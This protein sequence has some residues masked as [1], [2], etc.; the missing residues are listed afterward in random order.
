MQCNYIFIHRYFP[1]DFFFLMSDLLPEA[2]GEK[3]EA[4][5]W[6]LRLTASRR[7]RLAG[8]HD[9]FLFCFLKDIFVFQLHV[10]VEFRKGPQIL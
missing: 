8:G 6:G 2:D 10:R 4:D 3:G 7:L 1:Y 9:W 5:V